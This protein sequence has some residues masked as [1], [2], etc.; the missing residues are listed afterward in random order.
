MDGQGNDTL[1]IAAHKAQENKGQYYVHFGPHGVITSNSTAILMKLNNISSHRALCT[2]GKS[3][4]CAAHSACHRLVNDKIKDGGINEQ[5]VMDASH[6]FVVANIGEQH[7]SE[8]L[9]TMKKSSTK[10]HEEDEQL[11]A[12]SGVSGA[13]LD[14]DLVKEARKAEM[15]HVQKMNLYEKVP[16][17]ECFKETGSHWYVVG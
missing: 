16:K 17:S 11:V 1:N 6:E 5:R 2:Y 14:P 15:V 3:M 9:T 10:C 4:S 12:W 7:C 13:M 8:E